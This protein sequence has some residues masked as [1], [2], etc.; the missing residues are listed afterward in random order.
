MN[1][2]YRLVWSHMRRTWLAVS[3]TARRRGKGAPSTIFNVDGPAL[4]HNRLQLGLGVTTSVGKATTLRLGHDGELAGSEQ[5]H[6]ASANFRM[7]W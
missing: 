3:E 5:S 1:R 4:D 6:T 7:Q 2:A